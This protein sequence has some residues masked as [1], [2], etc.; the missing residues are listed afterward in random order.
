MPTTPLIG[1]KH[2]HGVG[3]RSANLLISLSTCANHAVAEIAKNVDIAVIS[4][5]IEARDSDSLRV[6]S[7][8][9][10]ISLIS[11]PNISSALIVAAGCEDLPIHDLVARMREV[12]PAVE[13]LVVRESRDE[14]SAITLASNGATD[15]ITQSLPGL[16][17]IF[18]PKIVIGFSEEPPN[19]AALVESLKLAGIDSEVHQ[20][21]NEE[22]GAIQDWA[23]SGAHAIISFTPP[24]I[25][26]VGALLS[27]VISIASDSNFH[28]KFLN[29]F[30]LAASA[31]V[32]EIVNEVLGVFNRERTFSEYTKS[33]LPFAIELNAVASISKPIALIALNSVFH[34]LAKDLQ[35]NFDYVEYLPGKV[36]I[37]QITKEAE[38]VVAL[39]TGNLKE[40]PDMVDLPDNVQ[41]LKLSEVGSL[42]DL[43]AAVSKLL[44]AT[45]RNSRESL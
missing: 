14:A 39:S 35:Q 11:H 21:I 36:D 32:P 26:P 18:N 41:V 31:T 20:Y 34:N 3:I 5:A 9:T 12:N 6:F 10:L 19:L 27:P 40:I 25:Y 2:Q 28:S 1:Y 16:G 29:D 38:I 8:S 17:E 33:V 37:A 30:D 15:L 13:Y 44:I 45:N 22:V 7:E 24:T 23:L 4:S 42:G 43:A